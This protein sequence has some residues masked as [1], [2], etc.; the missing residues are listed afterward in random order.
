MVSEALL[1]VASLEVLLRTDTLVQKLAAMLALSAGA[2][3]N[4]VM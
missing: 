2:V 3:A 1:T 4:T